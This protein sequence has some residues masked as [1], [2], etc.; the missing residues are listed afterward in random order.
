MTPPFKLGDWVVPT[1]KLY[2]PHAFTLG[3]KYKVIYC[4]EESVSF[5]SCDDTPKE[6]PSWY[7]SG[8]VNFELGKCSFKFDK[9]LTWRERLEK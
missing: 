1:D 7:A 5:E 6:Q 4:T 2:C 8:R 3:K 9:P